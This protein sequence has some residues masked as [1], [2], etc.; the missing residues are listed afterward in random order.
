MF[1][2]AASVSA[3]PGHSSTPGKALGRI[4]PTANDEITF[5]LTGAGRILGLDN[6]QPDSHESYQGQSRRAFHGLALVVVQ[7][8]GVP[9]TVTLSASSSALA[10]AKIGID[11]S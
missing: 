1:P 5:A 8:S 4:V 2:R 9:G 11:V 7:S 3:I 10:A 6:G